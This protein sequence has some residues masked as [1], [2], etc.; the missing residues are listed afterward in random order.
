MRWREAAATIAGL[1]VVSRGALILIATFL[2]VDIPLSYHGPTFSSAPILKSLT[3]SDSIYLLGIAASG[4]HV[5][6][7]QFGFRDWAFFPLY[8]LLT[9]VM[10]FI[11]LGDVAL[12]GV[13]VANAAFVAAL[14]VLYEFTAP[15][16][17][18]DVALRTLGFVTLAPGA[19]AFAMA[20]T[21][22]LFLLLAAGMFLAAERRRWPW[23]ALLYGLATLTRLQG[24][25]LGI[26]LLILILRQRDI[27]RREL[28]WLAAGP[29]AFA[30]FAALL[31]I[32]VGDPLGM[33]HAQAA[34]S[35]IGNP[36]GDFPVPVVDRFDPLVLILVG[37]MSAYIFLF[38]YVRHDRLEP[39]YTVMGVL[40]VIGVFA[41]GRLQSLPRYFAAVWPFDWLL[42]RREA[43]WF[44]LVG[45]KGSSVLFVTFA[46]LN[47][48]QALAP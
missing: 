18:H 11:T 38:V 26:P 23:V 24:I 4:Y 15:K 19:V 9:R 35:D 27:P 43:A 17:G 14:A 41:T 30:A 1:F 37:V 13:L 28:I 33:L 45:R 31:G 44:R 34:W 48:T 42:A 5:D 36:T 47:F 32:T 8:P 21:D 20:Y 2:E 12:A 29:L 46:V 39:E 40:A 3:G 10:S 6:P 16:L 7:I 25:V 22:S